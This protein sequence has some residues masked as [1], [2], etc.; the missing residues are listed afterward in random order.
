MN[1][2]GRIYAVAFSLAL[3]FGSP[4]VGQAGGPVGF[5][6]H[7][8]YIS[9]LI[10]PDA[11]DIN[12]PAEVLKYVLLQSSKIIRVQPTE[13][14][15]YFKFTHKGLHWQGNMRLEVEFGV[16]DKLHFAYFVVPAPWHNEDL[17]AYKAFGAK[18]GLAIQQLD[19]LDFKIN[20]RS[21]SRRLKLNDIR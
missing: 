7:E 17:G 18:D 10:R 9:A 6:A 3:T 1:A 21:I 2:L 15:S 8:T 5:E 16:P 20:F 14:Y 19:D 12:K 4:Q 13:N 11:F